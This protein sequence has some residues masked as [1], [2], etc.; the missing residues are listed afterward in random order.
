MVAMKRIIYIS[1]L[2][3]LF[4]CYIKAQDINLIKV[5]YM[6][7][8]YPGYMFLAPLLPGNFYL[9]DN[10]GEPNFNKPIGSNFTIMNPDLQSDGE[11]SLF[12]ASKYY[13]FDKNFELIDSF[14]CFGDYSIDFHDFD[15]MPDGNA[16]M[17]GGEKRKVDLSQTVPGGLDSVTVL[18][19]IIQELD[20]NRNVVFQWSTLD[21][22]K[23]TDLTNDNDLT[24]LS[25]ITCHMNSVIKDSDGN[26]ISSSRLLDEITKIDSKTGNI[27]W[28][29]GG[30]ECKNNQF[31]FLNDTLNGFYGFSHQH[32]VRRLSNGNLLLF[33]NGNLKP[34]PYSRAVEYKIDENNKTVEKVW[35]YTPAPKIFSKTMGNVQRL[36]NGNTLIGWGGNLNTLFATE[37]KPDGTKALEIE[38]Y[39]NYAV[40][41]YIYLMHAVTLDIDKS[42]SYDFNKDTNETNVKIFIESI[43][44][45]GNLSVA[46]YFNQP[47]NIEFKGKIPTDISQSRWT[48]SHNGIN[49]ILATM[50]FD[51]DGLSLPNPEDAIV[52]FRPIEG[53]GI[54]YPLIT[55]FIQSENCIEIKFK[56]SGE[57]IFCN[58]EPSQ[59]LTTIYPNDSAVDVETELTLVWAPMSFDATYKIQLSNSSDFSTFILDTSNLSDTWIQ[60]HLN[61][62]VQYFWRIKAMYSTGESDWSK[63]FMFVTGPVTLVDDEKNISSLTLL[64]NRDKLIFNN[65]IDN[66]SIVF[67]LYDYMGNLI[68][69]VSYYIDI[70]EENSFDYNIRELKRGI[71]FYRI[72]NGNN[73]KFG[74]IIIEK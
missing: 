23:I 66:G 9:I 65:F 44:G 74:K 38:G 41:K 58:V 37:V 40:Y 59:P 57:F 69:E 15:I 61:H 21:H 31:R 49:E 1:L 4:F 13:T 43:G 55:N 28:R 72:L 36:P 56:A 7:N 17:I 45:V 71:Y 16:L 5:T 8:P 39:Q 29:L 22:F 42:G 67:S 50:R 19:N 54:F 53:K 26:Y 64:Q 12:M 33:D 60:C 51:I 70:R 46:K 18:G 32:S 52:Y 63:T 62:E 10:S 27:I 25:I 68:D 20:T 3:F 14:S 73:L 48:V 30:K 2:I 11:I 47:H 35:E 34:E 6:D 24:Q